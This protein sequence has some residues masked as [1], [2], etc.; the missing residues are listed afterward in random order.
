MRAPTALLPLA[1]TCACA[2]AP[3]VDRRPVEAPP[4]VGDAIVVCGR[5]FAIGTPVVLW[6]QPPYYDASRVE[7]R[8][9]AA[10]ETAAD[11]PEGLRYQP[12]RV[13]R[14]GTERVLVEPYEAD[15]ERVREVVDQLV[16]HYDVAGTSETCFRVLHDQRGLSVHFLLDLDG[17]LYQTLDLRDQAFHAT[18]ANPRSVGV[19]IANVGAYPPGRRSALDEWYRVD[20]GGPYVAIPARLGDG[21]LRTTGF[22]ARPARPERVRG[23][24][25]G[26][27]L[28]MY[29]LTPEQ[30]DALVALAAGLARVLPRIEPDAPRGADGV[31]A[32]VALEPAAYD[33]FRGILGHH[34]VQANKV[35][36]GPAFDW[37]RFLARVRERSTGSTAP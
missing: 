18:K 4:R 26:Q 15:L 1:L 37:E 27:A 30:Y 33:A 31:V 16:L 28:E 19:E 6:D 7:P 9:A 34:H 32:T 13:R 35:D 20:A 3:R 25:Q 36:P 23:V 5:R 8:F 21:G 22:V 12:G 10:G 2:A 29:D 17:T 24:V 14:D 11:A